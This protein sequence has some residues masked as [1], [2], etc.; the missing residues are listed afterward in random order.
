MLMGKLENDQATSIDILTHGVEIKIIDY[1]LSRMK[2]SNILYYC[3]IHIALIV[4]DPSTEKCIYSDLEN[5]PE[6]FQ[7]DASVNYQYEIYRLMKQI[8]HSNYCASSTN[9]SGISPWSQYC[10]K[11]NALWIWYNM[12]F[13]LSP[14]ISSF[15][16]VQALKKIFT[17]MTSTLY[18]QVVIGRASLHEWYMN[19]RKHF[20]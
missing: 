8:V 18:D 16:K 20:N 9:E 17:E 11:T 5:D 14:K 2:P 6:I 4:L 12:K 13:V 7:G 1:T 19:N 3:K 15:K 10:P